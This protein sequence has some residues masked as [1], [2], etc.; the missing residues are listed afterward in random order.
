M[1]SEWRPSVLL[2]LFTGEVSAATV[3]D[4]GTYSWEDLL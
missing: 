2:C 4:L 1:G 3:V